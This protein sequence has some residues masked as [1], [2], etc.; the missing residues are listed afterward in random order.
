MFGKTFN[1]SNPFQGPNGRHAQ[2][3]VAAVRG[4]NEQLRLLDQIPARF[5][6]VGLAGP[7]VGVKQVVCELPSRKGIEEFLRVV[8][9]RPEL[10]HYLVGVFPDVWILGE[11]E[12]S[13]RVQHG[14]IGACSSGLHL[15]LFVG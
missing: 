11:H 12:S 15:A 6:A 14:P 8:V 2:L 7:C 9:A 10:G 4:I 1:S 13:R 5:F 3:A